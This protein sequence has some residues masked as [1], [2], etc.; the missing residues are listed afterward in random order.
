MDRL[1]FSI[2]EAA[3]L[4]S[5]SPWTIRAWIKQG[6]LSATKLGRRVVVTPE[7]LRELLAKAGATS[8]LSQRDQED[9]G[10]SEACQGQSAEAAG[11]NSQIHRKE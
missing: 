1:A 7:A 5:L 10:N 9:Y 6:K 3:A 8:T 11:S 4:L 2:N